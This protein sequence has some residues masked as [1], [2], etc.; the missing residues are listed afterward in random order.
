MRKTKSGWPP[1]RTSSKSCWEIAA[2]KTEK[3]TREFCL[4]G[5]QLF[6]KCNDWR[7]YSS[8]PSHFVC[9]KHVTNGELKSILVIVSM[10]DQ[11]YTWY[12][13]NL[14]CLISIVAYC[15]EPH[16]SQA[17]PHVLMD[18]G[19]LERQGRGDTPLSR[20]LSGAQSAGLGML[21]ILCQSAILIGIN[22]PAHLVLFRGAPHVEGALMLMDAQ[23]YTLKRY[24]R[25]YEKS[26]KRGPLHQA[27][28]CLSCSHWAGFTRGKILLGCELNGCI[29]L[30][31]AKTF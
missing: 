16:S 22:S 20:H 4:G 31:R 9:I 25:C 21:L 11:D 10:R 15:R 19:N 18:N 3:I 24:L 6:K 2:A 29:C 26:N 14:L 27:P 7:S 28:L 1:A 12:F 13:L 17:F 8:T 5:W 23:V 30:I